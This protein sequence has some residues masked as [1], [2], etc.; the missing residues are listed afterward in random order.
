MC[1][2]F[3]SNSPTLIHKTKRKKVTIFGGTFELESEVV[4]LFGV[5]RNVSIKYLEKRGGPIGKITFLLPVTIQYL[6]DGKLK[7][8]NCTFSA[9]IDLIIKFYTRIA[10]HCSE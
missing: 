4:C 3:N 10:K 8:S 5:T 2:G 7:V 6:Q 9:E 1:G